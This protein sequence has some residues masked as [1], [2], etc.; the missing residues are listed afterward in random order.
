MKQNNKPALVEERFFPFECSTSYG[1]EEEYKVLHWHQ[2]M[3]ICY[4]KH[5]T[6]K[7]LINGIEYNFSQGD[8]FLISNDEIHLC[9]DDKDL[10]MQ[11]TMFDPNFLQN[12]IATPFDY[13]YIRPFVESSECFCNKL[14]ANDYITAQLSEILLDIE[15][16]YVAMQKGYTLMIKAMLLKF[17]AL[18]I[19]HCFANDQ[20]S[21]KNTISQKTSEK[22][23]Q[24]ITYIDDHYSENINLK[25]I[26]EHFDISKPY[27]CSAFKTLTG[28][29]LID[30]LIK[31]RIIE[32]KILL[33]TT[34]RSILKI[35]EECGF[36]SLSNFN[37]QFK[38]LVGYSPSEYRKLYL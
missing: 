33:S 26:S 21:S 12:G 14:N 22:I 18:I 27:L 29:S 35:S 38:S 13:D 3:E 10:V 37:H 34:D 8:I 32:A 9:Y 2:E 20:Y 1:V 15:T 11:V 6:G 17:L 23:R 36:G 4:I 16:E 24:I 7:Y 31:K 28:N 19:R 30:F 25:F 5:G